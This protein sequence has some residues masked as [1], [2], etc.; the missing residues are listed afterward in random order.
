MSDTIST[1]SFPKCS[2][3]GART[4][5]YDLVHHKDADERSDGLTGEILYFACGRKLNGPLE[6]KFDATLFPDGKYTVYRCTSP[7]LIMATCGNAEKVVEKMRA[8]DS[9]LATQKVRP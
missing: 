1:D 2:V 8:A 4:I 6:W 5:R 7:W 3:C 9:A